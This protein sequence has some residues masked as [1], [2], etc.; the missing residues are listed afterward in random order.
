MI[1]W[2][3]A[4]VVGRVRGGMWGWPSASHRHMGEGHVMEACAHA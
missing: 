4:S 2:T 1:P 3:C